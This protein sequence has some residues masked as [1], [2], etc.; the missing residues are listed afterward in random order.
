MTTQAFCAYGIVALAGAIFI[1]Y[2]VGLWRIYR[3]I[4]R[5]QRSA[6]RDRE[7]LLAAH[8]TLSRLGEK[9]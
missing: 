6:D 8:A 5:D 3:S 7:A 2:L 9:K 1:A 4:I